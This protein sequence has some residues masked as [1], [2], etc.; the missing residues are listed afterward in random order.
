[1]NDELD[2]L[3]DVVRALVAASRSWEA[4]STWMNGRMQ[5]REVRTEESIREAHRLSGVHRDREKDLDR[6][7]ARLAEVNPE[8]VAGYRPKAYKPPPADGGL[9]PGLG[10]P[11]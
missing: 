1:M 11:L 3:R 10:P 2:R 5:R 4:F 9:G 7:L 6:A 8:L